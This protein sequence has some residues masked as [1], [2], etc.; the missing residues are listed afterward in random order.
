MFCTWKLNYK[1]LWLLLAKYFRSSIEDTQKFLN[2]LQ[3]DSRP[4]DS[5]RM[6][7][8]SLDRF[9]M[10]SIGCLYEPRSGILKNPL[11]LNLRRILLHSKLCSK[12][13]NVLPGVLE[14]IQCAPNNPRRKTT[15]FYNTSRNLLLSCA[16][17]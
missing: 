13:S 15:V 12:K 5:H 3:S 10:L 9:Q 6:S 11:R 7:K 14:E 17:Q 2:N 4:N 16:P 1:Y 8:F